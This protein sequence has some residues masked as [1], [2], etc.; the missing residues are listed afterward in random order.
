MLSDDLIVPLKESESVSCSVVSWL[1]V[2]PWTVAPT[3]LLCPWD[4][5]VRIMGW[6]VIPFSRGSSW[7]RDQIQVS[8]IADIFFNVWATRETLLCLWLLRK[9]RFLTYKEAIFLYKWHYFVC[10]PCVLLLHHQE[11]KSS[12]TEK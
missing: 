9:Q 4:F 12:L 11:C 5:P 3:R 7:L 6:I 10:L 8:C 2:T 1:F